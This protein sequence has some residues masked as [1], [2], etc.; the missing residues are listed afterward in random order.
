MIRCPI[1]SMNPTICPE[2]LCAYIKTNKQKL[3]YKNLTQTLNIVDKIQTPPTTASFTSDS[4]NT[5]NKRH[6]T[7]DIKCTVVGF[8]IQL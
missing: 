4:F 1:Y 2:F 8:C 7:Y 3:F 5:T 6:Q